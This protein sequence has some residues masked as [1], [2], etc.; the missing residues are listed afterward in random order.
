M[1]GAQCYKL[2]LQADACLALAAPPAPPTML[3][4][5]EVPLPQQV[6]L[7]EPQQPQQQQ[8]C[9]AKSPIV[10]AHLRLLG[11]GVPSA[12]SWDEATCKATQLVF[13]ET[14]DLGPAAQNEIKAVLGSPDLERLLEASTQ[15]TQAVALILLMLLLLCG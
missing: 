15:K 14:Q 12:Y 6:A 1:D 13:Y 3:M 10:A 9:L 8:E 7:D 5:E 2:A 4:G 11:A